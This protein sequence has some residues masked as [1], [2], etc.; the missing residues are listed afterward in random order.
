[1][2]ESPDQLRVFSSV[3]KPLVGFLILD[4]PLGISSMHAV[5]AVRRRAGGKGAK[6]GH[7]G[8]LDPLAAG[9]LV[10]AI[11][12]GATRLIDEVQA[13]PKRYTTT[14]DL[15]A[16]TSTDDLEGARSEV[17]VTE[18]PSRAAIERITREQF[19]GEIVQ[20]P[21]AYSAVKVGGRRAYAL[22]RREAMAEGTPG[23]LSAANRNI[24]AQI[25]PRTIRIDS[26]D[27]ISYDWPLLTLDIRCGKGTYI[28]RLA[29]DLGNALGTG[30]HCA[31]L[32][33]TEI[34]PFAQARTIALEKL[35]QA[36]AQEDL[37]SIDEVRAIIAGS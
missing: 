5:A 9:V 15:S 32:R 33:R 26:L 13:L 35:P 19:T 31:S 29:R 7:A 20:I 25:S 30:G 11:G 17:E 21:P 28:R 24:E 16:F 12:R 14:I 6:V 10:I 22:A 34:G 36:L 23:F 37:L 4:K 18:L 2:I 1:M 8:T 27:I 3:P